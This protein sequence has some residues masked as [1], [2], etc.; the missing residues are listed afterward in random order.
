[1]ITLSYSHAFLYNTNVANK[2]SRRLYGISVINETPYTNFC[3][4]FQGKGTWITFWLEGSDK[5]PRTHGQ[6]KEKHKSPLVNK[7]QENRGWKI[8]KNLLPKLVKQSKNGVLSPIKPSASPK[9]SVQLP[10]ITS[11]A[12]IRDN[13]QGVICDWRPVSVL[14]THRRPSLR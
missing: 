8:V 5:P 11:W 2:Q 6:N 10:P 9:R 1:M 14:P 4:F 7:Q 12:L 13:L 3:P